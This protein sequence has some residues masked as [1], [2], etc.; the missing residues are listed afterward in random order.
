[1]SNFTEHTMTAKYLFTHEDSNGIL[2]EKGNVGQLAEAIDRMIDTYHD[3][4][5][6]IIARECREK[7]SPDVIG[8]KIEKVLLEAINEK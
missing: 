5:K 2:V 3:Y 6:E 1:M 8:R 7:Y 4:D